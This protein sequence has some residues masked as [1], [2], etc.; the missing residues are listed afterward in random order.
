MKKIFTL[1]L[2]LFLFSIN[3]NALIKTSTSYNNQ[4][5]LN[6]KFLLQNEEMNV[7]D[8][9]DKTFKWKDGYDKIVTVNF[10]NLL[11]GD[12]T[13]DEKLFQSIVMNSM[14]KAKYNLK[15]K[16]SYVPRKLLIMQNEDG[17]I[18]SVEY[19]GK[20]AYGAESELKSMFVYNTSGE[21]ISS[22]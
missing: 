16:L 3:S 5:I 2:G 19:L 4:S 17:Y 21:L 20:N 18:V 7:P 14:V 22:F 6:S 15:N 9:N 8:F 1:S 12:K 13:M 11:P 10:S